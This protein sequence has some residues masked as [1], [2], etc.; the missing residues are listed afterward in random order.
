MVFFMAQYSVC[1]GDAA[2]Q[3]R[4]DRGAGIRQVELKRI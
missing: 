4:I 3:V 1:D 2:P